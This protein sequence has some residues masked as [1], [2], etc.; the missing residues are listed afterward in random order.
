MSLTK[1]IIELERQEVQTGRLAEVH[2][3]KEGTFVRAY[4]WSAF[5]CCRLLHDFKVS[6]RQFKGLD[7]PVSR[8]ESHEM[9]VGGGA[10]GGGG[11]EASGGASA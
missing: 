5:L 1:E 3:H 6:K 11:R 8:D 10:T 2:L 9:D 4:D 7:E